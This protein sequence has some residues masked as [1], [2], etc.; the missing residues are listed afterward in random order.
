MH[1]RIPTSSAIGGRAPIVGELHQTVLD[2]AG[3][4]AQVISG[5]GRFAPKHLLI[6]R[7]LRKSRVALAAPMRAGNHTQCSSLV[8]VDQKVVSYRVVSLYG[9]SPPHEA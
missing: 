8:D 4:A 6:D 7:C 1:R 5:D 3:E 2:R 9:L